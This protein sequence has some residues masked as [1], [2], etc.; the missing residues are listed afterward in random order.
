MSEF[1]FTLI[2]DDYQVG[3]GGRIRLASAIKTVKD[4]I[5]T[6]L[7]T[8]LGEWFL[9]NRVGVPW[10]TTSSQRGILGS[11]MQSDEISAILRRQI[12]DVD[13]VVRIET[14]DIDFDNSSRSLSVN[15]DVTVIEQGT[16]KLITINI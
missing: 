15:A 2:D 13:G 9:D 3:E 5:L 16:A 12:L 11:K 6:R 10:Y 7:Q 14:F 8:E 1:S 4:R